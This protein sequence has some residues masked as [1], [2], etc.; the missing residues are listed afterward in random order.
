MM[1]VAA[2]PPLHVEA[3]EA[4]RRRRAILVSAAAESEAELTALAVAGAFGHAPI[5]HGE[6]L[7]RIRE[8]LGRDGALE[9][10]AI[11][12]ALQRVVDGSYGTCEWCAGGIERAR[13]LAIPTSRTCRGCVP[14]AG[15]PADLGIP[16][17]TMGGLRGPGRR[18]G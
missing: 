12:A 4:L 16:E 17:I 2:T 3:A 18:P 1:M 11:E 7:T 5:T 10:A 6:A 14:D 8:R 15:D 13:L 9:L